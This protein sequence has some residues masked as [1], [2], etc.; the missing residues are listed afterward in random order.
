MISMALNISL[1][2]GGGDAIGIRVRPRRAARV[3][4][5]LV[6]GVTLDSEPVGFCFVERVTLM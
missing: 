4:D 6:G 5:C 3:A 1:L 2:R